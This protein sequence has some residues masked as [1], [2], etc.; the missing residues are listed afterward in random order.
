MFQDFMHAAEE[1]IDLGSQDESDEEDDLED[2]GG[3][4]LVF[5]ASYTEALIQLLIQDS[6]VAVTD[7]Q[8]DDKDERLGLAYSLWAENY[9]T[10]TAAS[11]AKPSA[12]KRRT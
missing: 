3:N 1:E 9:V 8:L 2:V 7:I 11:A 12:K 5:P 10:T 4:T 6:P